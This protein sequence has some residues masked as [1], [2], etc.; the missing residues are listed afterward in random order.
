M[1]SKDSW[2]VP[3]LTCETLK[4]QGEVITDFWFGSRSVCD[5]RC[6][7]LISATNQFWD[8]S[9]YSWSTPSLFSEPFHPRYT[10]HRNKLL[11][12]PHGLPHPGTAP[13][14]RSSLQ[15]A[16]DVIQLVSNEPISCLPPNRATRKDCP[17]RQIA[18]TDLSSHG[19]ADTRSMRRF[20]PRN[21]YSLSFSKIRSLP[22]HKQ[23]T[24][25]LVND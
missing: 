6:S 2:P 24:S 14:L 1:C 15:A 3:T 10:P 11:R 9:F 23:R 16:S 22:G 13:D 5:P 7:A 18:E 17:P 19:D 20:Y 4:K 25:P 21:P 12:A 8:R